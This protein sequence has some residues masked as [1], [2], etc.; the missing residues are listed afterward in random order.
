MCCLSR[1][2]FSGLALTG[3]LDGSCAD[4]DGGIEG[5]LLLTLMAKGLCRSWHRVAR[6]YL[7]HIVCPQC[8]AVTRLLSWRM[9]V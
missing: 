8:R 2:V 7:W 9:V 4:R 6:Q 3:R 5:R 1:D